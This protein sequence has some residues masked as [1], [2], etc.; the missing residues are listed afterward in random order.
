MDNHSNIRPFVPYDGFDWLVDFIKPNMRV[1]EYGS[2]KSTLWFGMNAGEVVAVERWQHCY[3][4]CASEMEELNIRNVEYVLKPDI[5]G[6]E[7]V[8][9]YSK[10]IHE[11]EGQFDLV[12]VDGHYRRECV[13]ECYSKAKYA[14]FMDNTDMELSPSYQD[15][16]SVMKSWTEGVL[17]DFY[18]YG[19]NPYTGEELMNPKA[20][21]VPVRWGAAVFLKDV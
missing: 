8:S 1:F 14:V 6:Q 15:A 3:E 18:S 19:L 4:T 17:I 7:D 16:Y 20:P 21:T 2:G 13:E 5:N 9:G 10:L 12:F 11:Y